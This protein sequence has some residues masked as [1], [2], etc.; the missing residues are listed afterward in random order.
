[1]KIPRAV[2]LCLCVV[3]TAEM[4]ARLMV[5]TGRLEQDKSL[6][7]LI[8]DNLYALKQY[9]PWVWFIG[10]STLAAGIDQKQLS[11]ELGLQI[12]KLCH[13]GATVRGSA[14]MLDFYLGEASFKPEY[15]LLFITKDDLNP[16][17][18]RVINSQRYLQAMTWRKYLLLHYSYLRSIRGSIY[19]I[20]ASLWSRLFIKQKDLE[21]WRGKYVMTGTGVSV[22]NEKLL[23]VLMKNFAFDTDGLLFFSDVC[24]QYGI[25]H[26][27]IILLPISEEYRKWHDREFPREPYEKIRDTIDRICRMKG[28]TYIDLGDPLPKDYVSDFYHLNVKG[29]EYINTVLSKKLSFFVKPGS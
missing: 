14:A 19:R 25:K 17:S 29:C 6:Q 24:R 20:I 4:A 22:D 7:K 28:I 3:F 16:N 10:N 13:G 2:I 27:G 11:K 15:V 1:M 26:I 23:Q 18:I 9:Q 21:S 5:R 12:I 8:E